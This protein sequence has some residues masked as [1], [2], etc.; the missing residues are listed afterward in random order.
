MNSRRA[1]NLGLLVGGLSSCS[2]AIYHF[3]LP[4]A[5]GWGPF[6]DRLPPAIRWGSYSINFFMSYLMLAGGVLTLRAWR[7]I[8]AGRSPDRRIVAAM[9]SFWVVNTL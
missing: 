4:F 9:A 5:F 6:L 2:M 7:H 3:V 1:A 8:R